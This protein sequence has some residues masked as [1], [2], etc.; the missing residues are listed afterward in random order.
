MSAGSRSGNG[1]LK[2]SGAQPPPARERVSGSATRGVFLALSLLLAGPAAAGWS[3]AYA[4]SNDLERLDAVLL[5]TARGLID[6]AA[7]VLTDVPVIDAL[8]VAGTRGV[9]ARLYR[10][11]EEREPHGAVADALARLAAAPNVEV[12]FKA[13]GALMHLKSYLVD[14]RVLRGGAANFSASGLKSQDNDR[15]ETDDPAAVAAFGAAFAAAW[16][17]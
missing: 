5:G 12:R 9:H 16:A 1:D 4:P 2:G 15:V 10:Q 6:M 3:V 8:A 17:R 7:Y 13:H 11:P 14:G